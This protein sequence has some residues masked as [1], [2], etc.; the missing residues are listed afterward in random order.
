MVNVALPTPCT[1]DTPT[2]KLGILFRAARASPDELNFQVLK[3]Y[4]QF[5]RWFME[6]NLVPLRSVFS[7][8]E[9]V[10]NTHYTRKTKEKM[11]FFWEEVCREKISR[12]A[13]VK[14]GFIKTER[15]GKFKPARGIHACSLEEKCFAG[16]V[17]KSVEYAVFGQ[18]RRYFLKGIPTDKKARELRARL[19]QVGG[20][21]M[22]SDFSVFESSVTTY[23]SELAEIPL[24][25]YMLGGLAPDVLDYLRR[26]S[27]RPRC[28]RYRKFHVK[29]DGARMSGDLQTS[30]C[31]SWINL[32][33][34]KFIAF[35]LGY[36]I[37]GVVEGDDGLFR[38]DGPIPTI[39]MFAQLG[40]HSKF[41]LYDDVGSA[42]FCKMK[43]DENNVQVTDFVEK[44]AKF[45]W[46]SAIKASGKTR[47]NLLYT[48]ALSLKAEYPQCPILGA[49]ADYVLR[50]LRKEPGVRKLVFDEDRAWNRQKLETAERW[51]DVATQVPLS[52]RLF[53]EHLYSISVTEQL[54]IESYFESLEFICPISHPLILMRVPNVWFENYDRFVIDNGEVSV[55][56]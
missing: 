40:F 10:E 32:T 53:Y 35:K 23:I 56:W 6:Q 21:Y 42:G 52:T 28:I 34:N 19:F 14:K 17:V 47:R 18:L 24:F 39:D 5:V 20:K 26:T 49:F 44:L 36:D 16:P 9:Y 12:D 54:S 30:L 27:S 45:G 15:Y 13:A 1:R 2:A 3:E 11:I 37:V 29:I 8:R 25:E 41:E 46:T 50:V 51:L 22:A 43:F 7:F 55:D 33:I 31:N 38:I 4:G 48:K